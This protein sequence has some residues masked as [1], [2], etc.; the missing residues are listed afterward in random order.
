MFRLD[1]VRVKRNLFR[2][3]SFYN[4]RMPARL[5]P[6]PRVFAQQH[7][8]PML[9]L[10]AQGSRTALV[11]ALRVALQHGRDGDVTSAF[12]AAS[13]PPV[14][15]L[16]SDAL[17]AALEPEAEAQGTVTRLF[18]LPVLLVTGG[19][20][21]AVLAGVLPAV[22]R[23]QALFEA[24]GALGPARNF[25]LSSALCQAESI[26][27][28]PKSRLYRIA[29]GLEDS[30]GALDL[31]PAPIVTG[32]TDEQVHLRFIVGAAVTPSHAPSFLETGSA[33]GGWGMA[34]TRELAEQLKV[35]G[36]SLLPIPRPPVALLAASMRG[37]QAR[38]ELALQVFVSRVLRQFRS[39]TGD[40]QALVGSVSPAA[41]G[42]R[43]WSPFDPGRVDIFH[44]QLTPLDQVEQ[45]QEAIL[46]LLREC[47]LERVEVSG[48]VSTPEAFA[49]W[50]E[51]AREH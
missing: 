22:A 2:T 31:P 20:A 10:A 30:A 5:L 51:P 3:V 50:D 26:E 28:V 47:R 25:G 44:W 15:T 16:L 18:A 24:N 13:S 29:H 36:L 38:E 9:R 14:W 43:F 11:Q 34:L 45:V 41:I 19:A 42:V 37:R 23:V 48:A 49:T 4:P 35:E 8:H 33:I 46:A 7:E 1:R 12:E 39:Q 40:P 21:G 32:G 17:A 6:D 27:R